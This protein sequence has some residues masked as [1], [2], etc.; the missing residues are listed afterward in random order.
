M[1]IGQIEKIPFGSFRGHISFSTDLE[2]GQSVCHDKT[3]ERFEF[4]L[5]WVI[6]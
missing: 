5:P 2:F 6:N 1:S 4:G 3:Y